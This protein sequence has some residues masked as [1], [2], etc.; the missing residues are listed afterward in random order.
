[1]EISCEVTSLAQA[2]HAYRA[3]YLLLVLTCHSS[4]KKKYRYTR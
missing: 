3:E 2:A 4:M 1:V